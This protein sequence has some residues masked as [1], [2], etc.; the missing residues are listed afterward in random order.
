MSVGRWSYLLLLLVCLS[1][2][3]SSHLFCLSV[4]PYVCLSVRRS[5]HFVFLPPP[6]THTHTLCQSIRPYVP[7]FACLSVCLP[8]CLCPPVCQFVCTAFCFVCLGPSVRLLVCLSVCPLVSLSLF[9]CLPAVSLSVC[10]YVSL[11]SGL[12]VHL[13]NLRSVPESL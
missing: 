9:A 12:S 1:L 13:F 6:P 7:L 5:S 10:P 2:G 8:A 3:R 11:I 4:G